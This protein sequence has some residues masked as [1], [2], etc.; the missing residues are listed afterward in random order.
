CRRGGHAET[1][2]LAFTP[3]PPRALARGGEGSGVGGASA[4]SLTDECADGPPPPTPPHR[5]AGGGEKKPGV[6]SMN[7]NSSAGRGTGAI[8]A[9]TGKPAAFGA[10]DFLYLAAAPTFAIMALLSSVLGGGLPDALCSTASPLSGMVSMYLLMSAFH[11]A[12]WLKLIS[13]RRNAT[14][15]S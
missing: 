8:D 2:R 7:E 14:C 4:N 5:F 3:L 9:E 15:R 10:A 1:E 6:K 13:R 12:P 11:L